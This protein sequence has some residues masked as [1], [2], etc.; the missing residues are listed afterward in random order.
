MSKSKTSAATAP[1]MIDD[2]NLSCAWVRLLLRVL[3]GAGTEAAPLILSLSGFDENGAVPEDPS[4]RQA[5][6]RLL[7]RKGRL[8]V[9]DVAFTI[10]P[11]R[12]W[13]MSRGD[14]ARLSRSMGRHSRAGRR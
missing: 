11:Q 4:V 1:V 3:D 9:D 14:R 6:D 7:K 5:L 13:E 8:V 12:L 2:S 10:F